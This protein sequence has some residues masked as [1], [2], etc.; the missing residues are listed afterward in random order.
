MHHDDICFVCECLLS[1]RL[2]HGT[3]VEMG[4][5]ESTSITVIEG[6]VRERIEMWSQQELEDEDDDGDEAMGDGEAMDDGE[7]VIDADLFEEMVALK[8]DINGVTTTCSFTQ[9]TQ[10]PGKGR[11]TR[12]KTLKTTENRLVS[13]VYGDNVVKGLFEQEPLLICKLC[14]HTAWSAKKSYCT[15]DYPGRT[16]SVSPWRNH[17]ES[18]HKAI[19]KILRQLR[20]YS[21]YF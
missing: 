11:G 3:V 17:C 14:G 9:R 6:M 18:K 19:I 20:F 5:M 2:P 1:L 12:K 7:R 16:M 10:V 4:C 8:K 21:L 13:A 15:G